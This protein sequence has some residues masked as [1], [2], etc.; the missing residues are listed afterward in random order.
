MRSTSSC[1]II[2]FPRPETEE[3]RLAR[4]EQKRRNEALARLLEYADKLK[5]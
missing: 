4:E 1:K 2:K 3:E 5:W